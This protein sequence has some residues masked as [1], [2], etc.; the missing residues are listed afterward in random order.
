[1]GD[2]SKPSIRE[3]L[4]QEPP[5]RVPLDT[6]SGMT[7]TIIIGGTVITEVGTIVVGITVVAAITGEATMAGRPAHTTAAIKRH[8]RR[9]L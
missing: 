8:R 3:Q 5:L 1:M 2:R 7:T 9:L 6:P 4:S